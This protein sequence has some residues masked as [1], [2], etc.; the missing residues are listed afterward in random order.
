MQPARAANRRLAGG[1]TLIELVTVLTLM[2]ILAG[3][4]APSLNGMIAMHRVRTTLDRVAVDLYYARA[5]A[6]R[7][8]RQVRVTFQVATGDRCRAVGMYRPYRG[9]RIEVE[10]ENEV[11]KTVEFASEGSGVCVLSDKPSAITVSSRGLVRG[12]QR[13][14]VAS[15]GGVSDSLKL[16]AVGRVRRSW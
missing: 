3:I 14:M 2:G 15:S 7:E 4:A 6:V 10:G 9:Y 13:G 1:F 16:S 12:H 5:I 8:G 11:A